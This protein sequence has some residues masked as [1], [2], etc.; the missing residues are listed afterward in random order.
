MYAVLAEEALTRVLLQHYSTELPQQFS[1]LEMKGT[2][3]LLLSSN[4]QCH[5]TLTLYQP[6]TMLSL[7]LFSRYAKFRVSFVYEVQQGYT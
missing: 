4:V 6:M 7:K 1:T 5:I 2:A 3:L